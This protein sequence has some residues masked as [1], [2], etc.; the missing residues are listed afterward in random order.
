MPRHLFKRYMPDPVSIREHKSLRFLGTLLHDANLWHLNRHSV[1]R[2]MAVGLFAAFIPIPMQMLLAAVL[3]I[4]LRSNMPISVSLVWLTN[5]ITMPPVFFCTYQLGAWLMNVPTR[6]LPDE[7][8][9]EWISSQLSTL[10]Q[11]FLLGS[12]VAGLVLGALAYCLTMLYWRWW[13][14]RQW[15]RRKQ[16]RR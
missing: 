1:A 5:P 16:Q 4:W 11:P 14:G 2:A 6:T 3:A 12:V 7:L 8:T 9:W 13:V 10:W 15:H